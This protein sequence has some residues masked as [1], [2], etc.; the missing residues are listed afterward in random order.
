MNTF[1]SQGGMTGEPA[2][3]APQRNFSAASMHEVTGDKS[4]PRLDEGFYWYRI[5]RLSKKG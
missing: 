2:C 4:T 5:R 1:F 3:T